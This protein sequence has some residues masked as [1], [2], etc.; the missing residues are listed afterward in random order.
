[1]GC[2]AA[3]RSSVRGLPL[4]LSKG[5]KLGSGYFHEAKEPR[6]PIAGRYDT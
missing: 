3:Y 2:I 4:E 6:G 1:M 5:L